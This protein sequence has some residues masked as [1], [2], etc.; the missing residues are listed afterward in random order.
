MKGFLA[1]LV[2]LFA[3]APLPLFLPY[4]STFI[5]LFVLYTFIQVIFLIKWSKIKAKIEKISKGSLVMGIL[6]FYPG[7]LI[8]VLCIVDFIRKYFS[9]DT[10]R[11]THLWTYLTF[12]L[13]TVLG[14]FTS[15]LVYF[16][17]TRRTYELVEEIRE[18]FFDILREAKNNDKILIVLP[19]PNPGHLNYPSS[20]KVPNW[21]DYVEKLKDLIKEAL[22]K[23]I[24]KSKW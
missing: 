3:G 13:V 1:L 4:T 20:S 17:V 24:L 16:N 10:Y 19:T 12:G 15:I 8:I 9:S 14:A 7:M 6:R 11:S 23:K 22:L 5:I 2:I 21:G 18:I